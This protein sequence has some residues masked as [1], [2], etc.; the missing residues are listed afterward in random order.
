MLLSKKKWKNK[1][2]K[3]L[4]KKNHTKKNNSHGEAVVSYYQRTIVRK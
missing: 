4:K 2:E 3:E 1:N